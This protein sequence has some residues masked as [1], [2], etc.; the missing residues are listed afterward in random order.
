MIAGSPP[1]PVSVVLA[2]PGAF[3]AF[4]LRWS[5]D[6][7][8]GSRTANG[9]RAGIENPITHR[10]RCMAGWADASFSSRVVGNE[11]AISHKL[12]FLGI[13]WCYDLQNKI[14]GGEV[15]RCGNVRFQER[16][17]VA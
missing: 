2:F 13:I 3:F 15:V 5:E 4:H 11:F 10:K 6:G 17:L 16:A 12:V 9:C 14:R 1:S 7:S 8:S